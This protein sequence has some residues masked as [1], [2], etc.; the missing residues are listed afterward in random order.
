MGA[1]E[2]RAMGSDTEL[3][4][5]TRRQVAWQAFGP[6][7]VGQ[8]VEPVNASSQ[9]KTDWRL[10]SNTKPGTNQVP[11]ASNP[12]MG[13]EAQERQNNLLLV[14]FVYNLACFSVAGIGLVFGS[15]LT[16]C[17][18]DSSSFPFSFRKW[19]VVAAATMLGFVLCL[20]VTNLDPI[21]TYKLND[22]LRCISFSSMLLAI[23]K[24]AWFVVGA[25]S[26][27]QAMTGSNCDASGP[28]GAGVAILVLDPLLVLA[29]L[30]FNAYMFWYD[31]PI[32]GYGQYQFKTS[33]QRQEPNEAQLA[34]LAQSEL[35]AGRAR[36]EVVNRDRALLEERER[37]RQLEQT[38]REELMRVS[39]GMPK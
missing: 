6:R 16:G 26:F 4:P 8:Q 37:T 31:R 9:A 32:E 1:N 18:E 36:A 10:F 14:A 38:A 35:A 19:E 17:L 22:L 15:G 11:P 33:S 25:I 24:L 5:M 30:L 20:Q 29:H 13:N 3:E 34:A 12:Q 7:T 28:F 2:S 23:F 27:S 39:A 21:L